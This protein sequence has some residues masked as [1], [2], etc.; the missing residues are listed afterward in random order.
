MIAD[1]IGIPVVFRHLYEQRI[2]D[3]F[4]NGV[5]QLAEDFCYNQWD[6]VQRVV[7][8][9]FRPDSDFEEV[10]WRHSAMGD[11]SAKGFYHHF[12][13]TCPTVDWG[14]WIWA[15]FIPAA[16]SVTSWRAIHGRLSTRD[17]L[18]HLTGT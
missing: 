12:R 4:V 3:Y 16:R 11:A 14:R 7:D 17:N 15:S 6:I 18:R 13:D 5:W 8:Y 10:I 9:Q 2:S 1:R